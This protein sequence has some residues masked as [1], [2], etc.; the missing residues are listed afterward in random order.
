MMVSAGPQ[1]LPQPNCTGVAGRIAMAEEKVDMTIVVMVTGRM[2]LP[3][4]G[5]AR[6]LPD[7][8]GLLVGPAHETMVAA[9][10]AEVAKPLLGRRLLPMQRMVVPRTM[11]VK[12]AVVLLVGPALHLWHWSLQ[13]RS[14]VQMRPLRS[15][16]Q[17][18]HV[19]TGLL[20]LLA[21]TG[22]SLLPRLMLL[23]GRRSEGPIMVNP[24]VLNVVT[25]NRLWSLLQV[26][27]TTLPSPRMTPR[28]I[29]LPGSS[30]LACKMVSCPCQQCWRS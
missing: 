2:V 22:L 5:G 10:I 15:T 17:M 20:L 19:K 1:G 27:L 23:A 12:V 24:S 8:T 14:L 30:S 13:M 3:V 18:R 16:P 7:K 29:G 9:M 28:S 4:Q 6:T 25:S 11:L 26:T 21:G